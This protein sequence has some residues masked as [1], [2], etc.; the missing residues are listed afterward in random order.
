MA[1]I[2]NDVIHL[3]V[4]AKGTI[5]Y[6]SLCFLVIVAEYINFD[7]YMGTSILSLTISSTA[8]NSSNCFNTHATSSNSIIYF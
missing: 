8:T 5:F 6:P 4:V 2:H 1:L 7:V 3:H